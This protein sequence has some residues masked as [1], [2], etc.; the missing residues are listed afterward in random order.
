MRQ[1]PGRGGTRNRFSRLLPK[2]GDDALVSLEPAGYLVV[3][4]LEPLR[5]RH[6][7]A[8]GAAERPGYDAGKTGD[9]MIAVMQT[10]ALAVL[11]VSVAMHAAAA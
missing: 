11:V 3:E 5:I 7:I 9:E 6:D 2:A 10:Q 8:A 1:S 4:W